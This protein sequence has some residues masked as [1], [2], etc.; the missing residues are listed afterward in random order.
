MRDS[1]F[2]IHHVQSRPQRTT[3][4]YLFYSLHVHYA[5]VLCAYAL[6]NKS[7]DEW[8][9][10]FSCRKHRP[11]MIINKLPIYSKYNRDATNI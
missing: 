1:P 8:P 2:D 9:V 10:L 4:S 3:N 11:A 6:L 7:L 5:V